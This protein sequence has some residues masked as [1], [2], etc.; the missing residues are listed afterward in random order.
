[1][2][3][4]RQHAGVI[5]GQNGSAI[6]PQTRKNRDAADA[7][8][9]RFQLAIVPQIEPS[10]SMLAEAKHEVFAHAVA[11]VVFAL[12]VQV[13]RPEKSKLAASTPRTLCQRKT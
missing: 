10:Q 7:V 8:V 13:D 4:N 2:F 9:V 3:E 1:L 5:F 11:R 12:T 6:D